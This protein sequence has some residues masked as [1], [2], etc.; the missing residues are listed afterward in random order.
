MEN[1]ILLK[2]GTKVK[3]SI[4]YQIT[5][6]ATDWLRND[7]TV[8][9]LLPWRTRSFLTTLPRKCCY[10][11]SKWSILRLVLSN[12]SLYIFRKS[13][14]IWLNDLSPS[15]SY[16][17]KP[18][19]W[20]RTPPP[21]TGRIGLNRYK[22]QLW[23]Y[24]VYPRGS[25]PGNLGRGWSFCAKSPTLR[26][27]LLSN[28]PRGRGGAMGRGLFHAKVLVLFI[29]NGRLPLQ[30]IKKNMVEMQEDFLRKFCSCVCYLQT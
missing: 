30:L 5:K 3:L 4:S 6:L 26:D 10:G 25:P 23:K 27:K 19:G 16:G 21:P 29:K 11:N 12:K 15:L 7:V 1:P 28:F 13:Y 20:C 18:Q 14:Q 8:A 17:Q 24:Q 9:S 22:L 2:F